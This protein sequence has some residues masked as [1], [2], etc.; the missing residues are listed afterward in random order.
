M[1]YNMFMLACTKAKNKKPRPDWLM[2]KV[3]DQKP[4]PFNGVFG[5]SLLHYIITPVNV[6][7]QVYMSDS[8]SFT[9]WFP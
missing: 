8:D 3:I 5:L 9:D 4:M 1:A 7:N 6:D 2:L